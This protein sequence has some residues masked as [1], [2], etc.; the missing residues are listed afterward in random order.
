MKEA[1]F[2]H[3]T[4][5]GR[6]RCDLCPHGCVIGE[7]KAGRCRSRGVRGGVLRALG[8]G[9]LSSGGVDP[10][11]KKPLYHFYPGSGI[12]SVGGWGCNFACDF[13]QNWNISQSFSENIKRY[14]PANIAGRAAHE[15]S[16]GIAYTYNE[17]L[18]N[19]EFVRECAELVHAA[20][21]KNV[22]V[23]NGFICP[24]PAAKLLPFIDALN[25]D[26][27]SIREAFYTKWC[28]GTLPPVLEF[29]RQA[30][31]AG[32][33]VEVTNLI[34]PTLNDSD[35]DLGALARWVSSQ[36]GRDVALHLS[37][38]HPMYKME[39]VPT[40]RETMER[41]YRVCSEHLDY[42]Y[43]GNLHAAIGQ[44]TLCPGCQAVLIERRGYTTHV[45]GVRD[46]N[47]ANCGRAVDF[48]ATM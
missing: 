42:V 4:E 33:L 47:C 24:E 12:L 44:N 20:G 14:T 26:I 40:P 21:R 35:Q 16:I 30:V 5:D 8:Y 39:I 37:A 36:L 17:P 41:A 13:C 28:R 15:G 18:I 43:V 2:W 31:G 38:Y 46:G 10:I 27:K 22:L 11:E 29:A 34:I 48:A 32:C 19:Y 7:G 23:T 45:S 1:R 6:V 9:V 3:K 25:I